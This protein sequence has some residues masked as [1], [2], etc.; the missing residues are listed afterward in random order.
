MK[1]KPL[2]IGFLVKDKWE[3]YTKVDDWKK[4]TYNLNNDYFI[5]PMGII[6]NIKNVTRYKTQIIESKKEKIPY[7]VEVAEIEWISVRMPEINAETSKYMLDY[8]KNH[9]KEMEL[10]HITPYEIYYKNLLKRMHK[11]T[12]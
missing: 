12:A 11:K 4:K 8:Y 6:K 2:Q 10:K 3:C 7:S 9:K 1:K 5:P